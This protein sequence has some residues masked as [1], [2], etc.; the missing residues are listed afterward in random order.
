[1]KAILFIYLVLE[2]FSAYYI[3]TELRD[4]T[5]HLIYTLPAI[6]LYTITCYSN[7]PFPSISPA[8]LISTTLNSSNRSLKH[9]KHT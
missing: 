2:I 1:M 3:Y 8:T 9:R 7:V 4:I 5:N 6:I